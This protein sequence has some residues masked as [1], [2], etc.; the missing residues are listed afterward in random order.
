MN[1]PAHLD[2]VRLLLE[3]EPAQARPVGEVPTSRF[4]SPERFALERQRLFS[5]VPSVAAAAAELSSTGSC[6]TVAVAGVPLILARG[7]DGEVRA[8]RNAC[9]H[10]GTALLPSGPPCVK[11]AFVCPYHAWTYDLS[12]ERIHVPHEEVFCGAHAGRD[13][14]V[15]AHA[16]VKHGLVWA[17]LAPFDVDA[18]TAGIA[19]D[20]DALDTQVLFKSS[21]RD[22]GANWK[23]LVDAFLDGY[24]IRHLHRDS[25]ARFFVDGKVETARAGDHIRAVTARRALL[26]LDPGVVDDVRVRDVAT[27]SLV[28]FP[29]TVVILHPDYTSIMRIEPLAPDRSR[30]HHTMLLAQEPASD[31][32]RAH[33]DKSFSLI[34]DGVFGREDLVIV[35]QVQRGLA[36]AADTSVLYGGLE[37]ASLWFHASVDAAVA[38]SA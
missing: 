38:S 30:F 34:D 13:A 9:R 4:T 11:K 31:A 10:R 21:S 35:E 15:P 7:G 2:L 14:L 6:V 36:A 25:V 17:S 5:Q 32:E 18:H 29:A 37:H 16:A 20:L 24:H 26:E 3:G 27:P 12:G 33:F 28:V 8:F 19:A 22:V 1:V 23:L